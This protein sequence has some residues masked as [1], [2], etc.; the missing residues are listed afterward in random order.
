ML[1]LLIEGDGVEAFAA[2][3][4]GQRIQRVPSNDRHGRVHSS[5]VTVAVLDE[6]RAA[7]V[8]DR[9]SPDDFELAWFS[10]SG[11]GG[12]HRNKTQNCVRLRHLPS[13]LVRTA[14]TRSRENSHQQAMTALLAELDRLAAAAAGQSENARRRQQVG[15]GERSDRHRTWAFQR[16]VVEDYRTG[17]SM[18]CADALKGHLDRLWD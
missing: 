1:T 10:G 12:Q 18:R 2:E 17:R 8:Y 6:Q 5:T 14:Q 3:A 4:G 16:D 11:S 15:S 9:R 13:G 7:T